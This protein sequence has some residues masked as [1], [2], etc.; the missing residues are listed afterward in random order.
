[1][2]VSSYRSDVSASFPLFKVDFTHFS[3]PNSIRILS[4]NFLIAIS[5]PCNRP[6]LSVF[7]F[8]IASH[9]Q[10]V[11]AKEWLKKLA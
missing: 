5:K 2:P 8:V 7:I 6:N 11:H 10:V 3:I 4:L 1:M 9:D